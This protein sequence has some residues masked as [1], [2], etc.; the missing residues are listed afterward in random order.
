MLVSLRLLLAAILLAAFAGGQVR[1]EEFKRMPP[2]IMLPEGAAR[3]IVETNNDQLR[4]VRIALGTYK[5][6]DRAGGPL[7][8]GRQ[9][10]LL[11]AVTP[12]DLRFS[13]AGHNVHD[14]HLAAGK[15]EWI[16]TPAEVLVNM[17]EDCEFLLIESKR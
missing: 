1:P 11:V 7:L 15:T 10:A 16:A 14:S 8:V 4:V 9:G 3:I 17:A 2:E 6:M 13:A 12:L 5:R